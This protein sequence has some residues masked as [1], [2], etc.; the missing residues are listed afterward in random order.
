MHRKLLLV[1][2]LIQ[3][4]VC[5]VEAQWVRTN[6]TVPGNAAVN[7][8]VV[9]GST[10]FA[11]TN[12]Q[13]VFVS[14]DNGANWSLMISNLANLNVNAL[15]VS[16]QY[17][18][19]GTNGGEGVYRAPAV[20]S[21]T[22]IAK[23]FVIPNNQT[24]VL[25]FT[26]NLTSLFAGTFGGGVFRT[27]DAGGAWVNTAGIPAGNSGSAL[28]VSGSYLFVGTTVGTV[29]RSNDNGANWTQ[30][31]NGIPP[32]S[33]ITAFA[34]TSF[35][36]LFAATWGLPNGS[37]F[38]STDNGANWM[39]V[40][41]GLPA[42]DVNSL[43]MDGA[44]SHLYAGTDA[45]VYLSTNN[46]DSWTQFNTG[47]PNAPLPRVT[48]LRILDRNL[49]LGTGNGQVWRRSLGESVPATPTLVLPANGATGVPTN[50]TLQWNNSTGATLYQ[51]QVSTNVG[52]T[53]L[54]VNQFAITDTFLV[55][56]NL[57]NNTLYFWRVIAS[58]GVGSSAWSNVWSFT[59]VA[60]N[61][62]A[63]TISGTVSATSVTSNSA[64]LNA[65]VN[66][67][68]AS[69]TAWF[70]WGTSST[71]ASYSS[72]SSQSIG[73]GTS[74][75]S[76]TANLTALN[77]NTTYYYRVV[78]QNSAGTRRGSTSSFTTASGQADLL[79]PL[80]QGVENI[81]TTGVPGPIAA[82]DQSVKAIAGGDSDASPRF[83]NVVLAAFKGTG[84]VIA[85][86][87]DGFLS[88]SDL[89][90]YHNRIFG[91]NVM[92]WLDGQDRKRVL[93][94]EGHSEW[95]RSTIAFVDTLRSRGY[96]V[97]ATGSKIDLVTLSQHG[98]LVVGDAWGDFTASELSAIDSFVEAGGGLLM[99]GLGWSWEPYNPGRTLDDYP[100]NKLGRYFNIRYIDGY[101]SHPTN[102]QNGS[103]I[104]NT[105]YPNL[106]TTLVPITNV[107][108]NQTYPLAFDLSQN[109][110]NPFN[111]STTIEFAL[112]KD[113]LVTLKVYNSLG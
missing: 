69:T 52:F 95:V 29:Y 73:S 20:P 111:P 34:P 77:A 50:P 74:V 23:G 75:V 44:T 15:V 5:M 86:G 53:A 54:V 81:Y 47:L 113:G 12:G 97:E 2:V 62:V 32:A 71:L 72:T 83:A 89:N 37:V 103:P 104:F 27:N 7:A 112:P 98:V 109:F 92:Q 63:P 30:V 16:G 41:I 22:W 102:N 108:Q 79:M 78:G 82:T 28:A 51:L 100:M 21:G 38:R 31:G 87:H 105:F 68:G 48:S 91:L 19:A 58:N 61:P 46:G 45:G 64:T 18:F 94:A 76:V 35:I 25:S 101:I 1:S 43:V 85:Y 57:A 33:I 10:F 110:P 40:D 8:L 93:F 13:G 56:P 59:T 60:A 55:V 36:T 11:G 14:T 24:R 84:R 4:S 6:L 70:E 49:F 107:R 39:R 26:T 90:L 96:V 99:M 3:L 88:N 9:N 65:S 66:P 80:V 67:N 17:L 106:P 42:A